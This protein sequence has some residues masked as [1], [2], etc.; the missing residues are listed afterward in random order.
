MPQTPKKQKKILTDA[1]D[2]YNPGTVDA[3]NATENDS[4]L[5][6]SKKSP[7]L[8]RK[9]NQYFKTPPTPKQFKTSLMPL[10]VMLKAADGD[11]DDSPNISDGDDGST[12]SKISP[13]S[14]RNRNH[15]PDD[16]DDDAAYPDDAVSLES[17]IDSKLKHKVDPK[18]IIK[19]KNQKYSNLC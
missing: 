4:G 11:T 12:D 8:L 17:L 5:T 1:P 13:Y 16:A 14:L 9:R 18:S 19:L 6:D 15:D 3:P 7:Y 2:T 10:M